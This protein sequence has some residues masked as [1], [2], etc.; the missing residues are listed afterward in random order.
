MRK[1]FRHIKS[2]LLL[3]TFF[4]LLF[5]ILFIFATEAYPGGSYLHPTEKGYN[6]NQNYICNLLG[7]YALNGMRNDAVALAKTALF[8]LCFGIGSFFLLFTQVFEIRKF[9]RVFTQISGLLSMICGF[10]MYTPYHDA[11]LNLSAVFGFIAIAGTLSALRRINAYPLFWLG[12]LVISL[13]CL[14]AFIYYTSSHS[15][16]LPLLQKI[17]LVALLLWFG[18]INIRFLSEESSQ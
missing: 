11:V 15:E 7:D 18:S 8:F 4:L 6:W 9:W 14:N 17:T 12:I 2:F 16:H 1:P 3:P 10:F 13:I 5:I